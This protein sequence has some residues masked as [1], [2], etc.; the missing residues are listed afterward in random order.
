MKNIFKG[1]IA[2]VV[3]IIAVVGILM[4]IYALWITQKKQGQT[5]TSTNI[6]NENPETNIGGIY[7]SPGGE[8]GVE[9]F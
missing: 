8:E 6:S 5:Q 4:A 2:K 1:K 9:R 3:A 7:I